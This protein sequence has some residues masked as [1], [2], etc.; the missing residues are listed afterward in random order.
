MLLG[1]DLNCSLTNPVVA[2]AYALSALLFGAWMTRVLLSRRT[3]RQKALYLGAL[4][5]LASGGAPVASQLALW[6]D[7]GRGF[8][9]IGR[10]PPFLGVAGAVACAG[11]LSAAAVVVRRLRLVRAQ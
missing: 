1:A 4:A 11:V 7:V 3:A 2:T 5:V 6:V 9:C 10:P 8:G